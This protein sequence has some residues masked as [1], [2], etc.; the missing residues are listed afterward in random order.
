MKNDQRRK[1]VL[2][3]CT[4]EAI[5]GEVQPCKDFV[6]PTEKR[7]VRAKKERKRLWQNLDDPLTGKKASLNFFSALQQFPLCSDNKKALSWEFLLR[8]PEV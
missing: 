7:E 8:N 2:I 6:L 1:E 3:F 5:L 4:N